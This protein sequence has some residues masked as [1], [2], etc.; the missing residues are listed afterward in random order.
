MRPVQSKY[1]Q[2][3]FE[4][5]EGQ[6]DLDVFRLSWKVLLALGTF[7]SL[8]GVAAILLPLAFSVA[9]SFLFGAILFIGGIAKFFAAFSIH[10]RNWFGVTLSSG[11]VSII[12]GALLLAS[13]LVGIAAITIILS[14]A[15]IVHGVLS[16]ILGLQLRR[17]GALV[18][19]FAS[20]AISLLVGALLMIG[21]P[22]SGGIFV[23]VLSGSVI[24]ATGITLIMLASGLRRIG[25][26]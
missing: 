22:G 6:G 17:S 20:G 3:Y 14:I 21:W 10:R 7:W 2:H 9:F 26:Q 19:S 1:Q 18:W 13:P 24:L 4:V 15:F 12:A 23:G 25:S 11:L 16:I 5:I 8:L